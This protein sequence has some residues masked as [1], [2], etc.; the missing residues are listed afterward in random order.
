MIST[1]LSRIDYPSPLNP[2]PST[3]NQLGHLV[4]A[5]P[6]GNFDQRTI[7]EAAMVIID[8]LEAVN[9]PPSEG[10]KSANLR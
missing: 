1:E 3:R 4:C 7:H 5:I 6:L 2:K 8:S 10:T 9:S